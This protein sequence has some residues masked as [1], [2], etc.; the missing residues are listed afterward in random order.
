MDH[1]WG[2]KFSLNL[3]G[4]FIYEP[5]YTYII[6]IKTNTQMNNAATNFITMRVPAFTEVR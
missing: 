6:S 4:H 2:L 1:V 5:Y 3:E